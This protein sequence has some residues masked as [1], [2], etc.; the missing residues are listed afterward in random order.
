MGMAK[1]PTRYW[2][3]SLSGRKSFRRW[4]TSPL[5]NETKNRKKPRNTSVTS[6]TDIIQSETSRAVAKA[7]SNI[8]DSMLTALSEGRITEFVE[9]FDD[10]F[11]FTDHA[12]DL[13]FK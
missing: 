1:Q 13:E 7:S 3:N 6:S 5:K 8:L 4:V 11:K 2:A 12:L 10:K 9:R